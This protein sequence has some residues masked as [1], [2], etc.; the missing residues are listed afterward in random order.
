MAFEIWCPCTAINVSV[1]HNERSVYPRYYTVDPMFKT[2]R[3]DHTRL[4]R[5]Y[6]FMAFEIWCPCT[7]INVSVRHNER[8]V[9]PRYYTVDPM[10]LPSGNPFKCHEEV[11]SLQPTMF[12]PKRF[13]TL[14]HDVMTGEFS[15][16]LD[17]FGFFFKHTI[18]SAIV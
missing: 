8:S 15:E 5:Q 6:L 14:S 7:A 17:A 16:G 2:F 9:Y 4:Q 12:P 18:N 1:R 10:L 11:S 13:D 3:L